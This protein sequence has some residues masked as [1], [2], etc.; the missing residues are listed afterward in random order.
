VELPGAKKHSAADKRAK[1]RKIKLAINK[2]NYSWVRAI[3]RAVSRTI[4]L[5]K[6][7]TCQP[8]ANNPKLLLLVI[9]RPIISIKIFGANRNYKKPI[10]TNN[11]TRTKRNRSKL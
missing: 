5:A 7:I 11:I 1:P 8:Y 9:T 3:S 6:S 2:G 4:L 10:S